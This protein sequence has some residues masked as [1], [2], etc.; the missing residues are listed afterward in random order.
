MAVV[1]ATRNTI[2]LLG[3]SIFLAVCGAL[4]NNQVANL[5]LPEA[6]R[7][8]II[9]GARTRRCSADTPQTLPPSARH[10]C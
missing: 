4:L 5:D 7:T 3:G 10:R 2:R 9:N 1:T 8:A 6:L